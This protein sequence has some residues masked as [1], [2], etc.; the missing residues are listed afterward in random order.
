[1]MT[2]A[3][4][5]QQRTFYDAR[6]NVVG[7]SATDS[8]GSTTNYDAGGKVISRES[9]SGNATTVHDAGGRNVGKVTTNR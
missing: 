7:R 8:Q 5:A 3:A 6:G 9:T 4:L 2:G 1:M